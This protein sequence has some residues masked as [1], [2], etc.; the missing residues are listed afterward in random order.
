MVP[1]HRQHLYA[2]VAYDGLW[3]IALTLNQ[4]EAVL[5]EMNCSF[6][7]LTGCPS[8]NRTTLTKMFFNFMNTTSFSGASVC[9]FPMKDV[10]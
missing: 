7:N 8:M 3:A 4:T 9:V 6:G 10:Q 1:Q 2:G 5:Q